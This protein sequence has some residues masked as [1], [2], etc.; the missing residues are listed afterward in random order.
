MSAGERQSPFF[1]AWT[2]FVIRWRWPL[3]LLTFAVTGLALTQMKAHLRFDS[4]VEYF[5]A[6]SKARE[7]LEEFQEDFGND[8]YHV[9]LIEGDVFTVAFLDRLRGLHDA[10]SRF[11]FDG[12]AGPAPAAEDGWGDVDAGVGFG[13]GWGDGD[14]GVGFGDPADGDGWGD[15][16]DAVGFGDPPDPTAAPASSSAIIEDVVSLINVRQTLFEGG[17]VRVR[18]L[19]DAGTPSAPEVAALKAQVLGDPTLA[20]YVV[21]KDGTHAIVILRTNAVD[22]DGRSAIYRALKDQVRSHDADGFKIAVTGMPALNAELVTTMQ[23]DMRRLIGGAFLVMALTLGWLFRRPVGIVAPLIVVAMA[24]IWTLGAMATFRVPVTLLT[25]I[26]PAFLACVGLGDSIHVIAVYRDDRKRGLDQ[27]DA[28]VSAIGSTGMPL[29]FTTLTT[30]V[31]LLSFRFAKM[32]AIA[33]M[34]SFAAFGVIVALLHSVTFLPIALSLASNKGFAGATADVGR[35]RDWID[36]LLSGATAISARRGPLPVL[37]AGTVV[38]AIAALGIAQ[39]DVYHNPVDWMPPAYPARV[40][41]QELDREVGGTAQVNVVIDAPGER[42]IRDLAVL[43]GMER[44]DDHLRAFVHPA[45][46]QAIVTGTSSVLDII[47]ETN[48]ALHDGDPAFYALPDTQRGVSDIL[49]LFESAAPQDLRRL[50]TADLAKSHITVRLKWMDATSYE[51]FTEWIDQGIQTHL[52]DS[53][54][55][56]PT[57]SVYELVTTVGGLIGDLLRSFGAALVSVTLMMILLLRSPKLG[58]IAMIPNLMP[59]AL[60]MG[61][62]GYYGIPLD[63]TNLL[64]ASIVI[65]VA[66]DNTVHYLFQWKSAFYSGSGLE[67]AIQHALEHAGRALVG[68]AM[69]LA[70]GFGVYLLSA[71]SNIRF[72][73]MLVGSACVFALFTNLIFAP[74]LLR[75]RFGG[76]DAPS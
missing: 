63:L 12:D 11:S 47:K 15:G 51:P 72:F 68:T 46:G 39:M 20:G 41:L 16:D 36:R 25:N 37:G 7:V 8:T 43:Q 23:A 17:A 3:L 44:L 75:L 21:G 50:A 56:R 28:I 14:D 31:G 55:A 30:A 49:L 26:V 33:E 38:M 76:T 48:R 13:D 29:L 9:V 67:P 53:A 42:G 71:M 40:A 10:V 62:M 70:L 24:A 60:V 1:R 65:G 2:H 74:A 69:I 19:L 59:V 64:I 58:L 6:G 27:H 45:T 18:G 5:A 22:F 73:G 52:A 57:G 4:S 32:D 34:G 35:Q 66:V 54:E 61:F